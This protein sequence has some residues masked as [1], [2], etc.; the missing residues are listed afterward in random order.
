M[1]SVFNEESPHLKNAEDT[2]KTIDEA[3]DNIIHMAFLARLA[4]TFV[5]GGF[6]VD[7]RGPRD[8]PNI[9]DTITVTLDALHPQDARTKTEFND[10]KE[11]LLDLF[12]E[13]E[14]NP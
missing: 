3:Q 5:N 14:F 10:V 7:T 8:L 1:P 12:Q 4:E 13:L 9:F 6:T 11:N 2:I